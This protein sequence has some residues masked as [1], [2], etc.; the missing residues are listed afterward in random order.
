MKIDW[1]PLSHLECSTC[2]QRQRVGDATARTVGGI[3]W[4]KCCGQTMRLWTVAEVEV[5][6]HPKEKPRG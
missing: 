2:H 1:P 3:G 4:P 5:D 6:A